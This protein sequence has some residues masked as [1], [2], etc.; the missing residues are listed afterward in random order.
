MF[1]A[2]G[3]Q[4]SE[5]PFTILQLDTSAP[6][7]LV[8][9]AYFLLVRRLQDTGSPAAAMQ[10]RTLH[11]AYTSAMKAARGGAGQEPNEQAGHYGVLRVASS[12]DQAIIELAY[13]FLN[14]TEGR[15]PDKS[16]G[17]YART[18]AYRVLGNPQLRARYDDEQ[19]QPG[20]LTRQPEP[21]LR[22]LAEG[23]RQP[24]KERSVTEKQKRGLFGLGRRRGV[25]VDAGDTRVRGL[26]DLISVEPDAPV[27]AAEAEAAD[28]PPMAEL[29]FTAGPRAG[30][31]IDVNGNVVQL[32]EGKAA[33]SVWRHGDRFLL[34]HSGRVVRIGGVIPMLG[35]VVL[36]D[37]DDIAA[38]TDRA[39]FVVTPPSG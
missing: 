39:R 25:P 27:A 37:G 10:A 18:E 4:P 34:R 14:R 11:A 16:Y 33:A 32:G 17:R 36:D 26:R 9:D 1:G 5:C 19:R 23:G 20:T 8:V 38:G 3:T 21:A 13:A 6:P 29:V 30:S 28:A 35:I 15:L 31:R 12:A 24:R 22:L 2:Q 7:E